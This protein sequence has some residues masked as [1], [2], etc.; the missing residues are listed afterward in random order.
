M[1]NQES[2][3]VWAEDTFGPASDPAALV[4]RAQVELA[5]LQ[6]A[7]ANKDSCEIGREAADVTILLMRLLE[8]NGLSLQEEID[9]K[10]QT[11]RHRTWISKGDGTGHHIKG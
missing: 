1:E 11:N 2:I 8:I 6:E 7:V 5:E 4:T 10:M 3:T 9:K